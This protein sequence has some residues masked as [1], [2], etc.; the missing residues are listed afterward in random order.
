[1]TNSEEKAIKI[2]RML[3]EEGCNFFGNAWHYTN[4]TSEERMGKALQGGYRE[5]VFLMTKHHGRTPEKAKRHVQDS[6]RRLQVDTIDLMQFHHLKKMVE[7]ERIY[8]SGVLDYMREL[9]KEG[10]IRYIGF[11]G[12]HDP[13][14]HRAMIEG[15]FD[16]D[17]VQMPVNP[18]DYHYRSFTKQ[19][20]PLAQENNIAVIAMKTLAAGRIPSRNIV[21]APACHRYVMSLPV[22]TVCTGMESVDVLKQNLNTFKNT[23]PM[24]EEEIKTML[25]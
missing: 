18:L 17:T 3:I 2:M 24:G 5:K 4:G 13:R 23:P 20:L 6:L 15:G 16:W 9:K 10:T 11:T 22:S 21:S 25:D 19:I 7:V 1:M 8:S 14:V 12:H